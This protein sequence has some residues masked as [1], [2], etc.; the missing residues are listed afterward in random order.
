MA[1]IWVRTV[2]AS[3]ACVAL[4]CGGHVDKGDGSGNDEPSGGQGGSSGGTSP[5]TCSPTE[6]ECP[7]G[8]TSMTE[9]PSRECACDRC[10]EFEPAPAPFSI[11]ACGGE[12][13]GTWRATSTEINGFEF[14]ISNSSGSSICQGEVESLSGGHYLIEFADGGLGKVNL[15]APDAVV[16]FESSCLEEA[17]AYCEYF[18]E[19]ECEP[20][21]CGLCRC[22]F[23]GSSLASDTSWVR[24]ASTLTLQTSESTETLDYCVNDTEMVH[25]NESGSLRYTLEKV[26]PTGVPDACAAR[27]KETCSG[28]GCS[29]GLCV[30]TGDCDSA[31]DESSC[32]GYQDCEWEPDTCGGEAAEKCELDDYAR[33]VPGC[34]ILTGT[35]SCVGTAESC[36]EQPGCAAEGCSIGP[37]CVGGEQVCGNWDGAIPGCVCSGSHCE[38]AFQCSDITVAGDCASA[39]DTGGICEWSKRACAGTPTACS[40]LPPDRCQKTLGCALQAE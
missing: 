26:Y 2:V 33:G 3:V 37:G 10:P 36:E 11:D 6:C 32:L 40:D 24:E 5:E 25:V 29:L 12:P 22:S 1:G 31:D 16:L 9:C 34:E 13:F 38:G 8:R 30:G 7:D 27:T 35:P 23:S 19:Y 39:G 17:G 15:T 4:A 21:D 14:R 18:D 28:A 20:L